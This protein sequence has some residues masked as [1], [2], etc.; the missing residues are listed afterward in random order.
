MPKLERIQQVLMNV[1]RRTKEVRIK[2]MC[3]HV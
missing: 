2:Y 1:A 3:V